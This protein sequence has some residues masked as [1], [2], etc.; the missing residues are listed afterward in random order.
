MICSLKIRKFKTYNPEESIVVLKTNEEFGGLS[1]MA[2]GFPLYING[3]NI[4]TSEALYQACRFP[5]MPDIQK[6]IINKNSPMTAKMCSKPYR[7]QSRFDWD[8]VREKIMYW[9]LQVKLIQNRRKFGDLLLRTGNKPIVEQSYKDDFWGTKVTENG[10][11]AGKNTLGRLLMNLRESLK[12]DDGKNLTRVNALLI[13][14]FLLF[15]T[16]IKT[17]KAKDSRDTNDQLSPADYEY[18][19]SFFD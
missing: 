16:P 12:S 19:L 2:P 17:I 3:I 7:K 9:S 6:M 10:M 4:R 18:Q 11:L 13:D 8:H 5:H 1:N 14:N 15:D